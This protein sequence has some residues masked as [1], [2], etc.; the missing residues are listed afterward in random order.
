MALGAYPAVTLAEARTKRDAVKVL[1]AK[2][3][4]PR[5]DKAEPIEDEA[6]QTLRVVGE[7]W[8]AA[9]LP[10][11]KP[12]YSER[13]KTRLERDLFDELG[14]MPLSAITKPILLKALRKVEERGAT[15]IAKRLKNHVGEIFGDYVVCKPAIAG[16]Q[17]RPRIRDLFV[18]LRSRT[19]SL[20]SFARALLSR[21]TC[22]DAALS[23]SG[24]MPLNTRE[25][26]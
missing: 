11:W 17:K 2:G 9:Q 5:K 18:K 10:Q 7:A 19:Y 8:F 3:L 1:L 4:D 13:I 6:G 21:S 20:G 12:S 25:L 26:V 24:R 14:E 23:G 22:R 15:H 16:Q